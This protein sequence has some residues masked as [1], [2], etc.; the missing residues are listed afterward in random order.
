MIYLTIAKRNDFIHNFTHYCL[1]NIM[2]I[3]KMN[4]GDKH[5]VR[6]AQLQ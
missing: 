3:L 1:F 6:N 2:C 5:P 4:Y